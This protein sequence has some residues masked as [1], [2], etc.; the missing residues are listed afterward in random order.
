MAVPVARRDA[1]QFSGSMRPQ[2][3]LYH[4]GERHTQIGTTTRPAEQ[5]VKQLSQA[6]LLCLPWLSMTC[7][8]FVSCYL[9]PRGGGFEIVTGPHGVV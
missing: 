7:S 3:L 4:C 6:V 5:T 2:I 8:Y 9:C 1:V